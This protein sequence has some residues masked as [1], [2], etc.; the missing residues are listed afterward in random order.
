[1]SRSTLPSVVMTLASVLISLPSAQGAPLSKD[2]RDAGGTSK[3]HPGSGSETRT[4]VVV[5]CLCYILLLAA[6]QGKCE[7]SVVAWV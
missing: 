5:V 4:I 6:V 3:G 2:D 7:T 1:M